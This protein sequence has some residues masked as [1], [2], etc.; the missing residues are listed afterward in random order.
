MC[1]LLYC[2][3]QKKITEAIKRLLGLH[4][5]RIWEGRVTVI[6]IRD[7]KKPKNA[8]PTF[9]PTRPKIISMKP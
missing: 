7:L 3:V 6:E 2:E 1:E 5:L 8:S 9:A 4:H